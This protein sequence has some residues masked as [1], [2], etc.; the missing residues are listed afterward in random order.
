MTRVGSLENFWLKASDRLC[1]GSVEMMR[2]DSRCCERGD[3]GGQGWQVF[4]HGLIVVADME[5]T[6]A[7]LE[8]R[9]RVKF[10]RRRV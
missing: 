3:F 10:W 1:A 4:S 7:C 9:E 6:L 5:A 8:G 2:T